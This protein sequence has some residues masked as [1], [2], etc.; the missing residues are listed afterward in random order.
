VPDELKLGERWVTCDEHKAPLIAIKNGACFAA[1]STDPD[2]WRSY[3]TALATYLENEHIAGVGRVIAAEE[4]Y[5]GV[6]LDD[7]LDP[8]SGDLGPWARALVERL[9]S[10]AEISPSLTGVKIW[11]KAPEVTTAY[12][13]PG[14]EIYPRG[15]YFTVTGLVLNGSPSTIRERSSELEAVIAEEFPKV[16]RDRTAYDGPRRV[17]DLETF[18]NRASVEV[19]DVVSDGAAERKYR[20]LC[21]WVEEHTRGDVSGTY[22]GQYPDGAL[23]FCCWHSHCSSRRWREFRRHLEAFIHLGRKGRL[24]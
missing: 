14:L 11:I 3:E 6:D 22:C 7:C 4:D 15:R 19:Y 18:L 20:V 24:R 1:K 16:D 9:N 5:V 13:K 2:T 12:K 21:P 8:D 10:Y 17:L 23:F